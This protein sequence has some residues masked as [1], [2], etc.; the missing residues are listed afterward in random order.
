MSHACLLFSVLHTIDFLDLVCMVGLM[1]LPMS[2][3]ETYKVISTTIQS[4]LSSGLHETDDY[5]KIHYLLPPAVILTFYKIVSYIALTDTLT[6][7]M[8]GCAIN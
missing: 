5:I 2:T 3:Y 8:Y 1:T 4:S 6:V 7:T